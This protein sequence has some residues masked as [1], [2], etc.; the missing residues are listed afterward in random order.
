MG[1][2]FRPT[3][4]SRDACQS[5]SVPAHRL[6][7]VDAISSLAMGSVL[8][9]RK[10]IMA[11]RGSSIIQCSCNL[12]R[13]KP[14]GQFSMS[15]SSR[16][17]ALATAEVRAQRKIWQTFACHYLLLLQKL[18]LL[19][20]GIELP[21][22]LGESGSALCL[23]R[24]PSLIFSGKIGGL[25]SLDESMN[26][27]QYAKHPSPGSAADLGRP[28]PAILVPSDP[29]HPLRRPGVLARPSGQRH[30]YHPARGINH[31]IHRLPDR[32][33]ALPVASLW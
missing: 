15:P 5:T 13:L 6:A 16:H 12:T 20:L 10:V 18:G 28:V 17:G 21:P 32:D 2:P 4:G 22:H 8:I 30:P 14:C 31:P 23:W 1:Q 25:I 24:P 33:G 19:V 29:R 7:Q 27:R 3:I 9:A 11:S 26:R